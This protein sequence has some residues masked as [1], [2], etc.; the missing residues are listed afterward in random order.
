MAQSTL[1]LVALLA[2]LGTAGCGAPEATATPSPEPAREAP[3]ETVDVYALFAPIVPGQEQAWREF[4]S[5]LSGDRAEAHARSLAA[6]GVERELVWL[7]RS[8]AGSAAVVYFEGDA[9][10]QVMARRAASDESH[11]VWFEERIAELHGL[12]AEPPPPN[13]L[14]FRGEVAGVEGE[15][16]EY[17]LAAPILPGQQGAFEEL[18]RGLRER[19]DEWEESRRAKGIAREYVWEQRSPEGSYAVVCFEALDAAGVLGR[20]MAPSELDFDGWFRERI[21][22]IHGLDPEQL[23][24]PNE[25]VK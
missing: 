6:H 3:A 12:G 18:I 9:A 19:G 13:E 10:D 17:A 22:R 2:C 7:Q 21:A 25:R 20:L 4:V 24:A 1:P 16:E 14:V 23:P 15:T 8:D 5:E 11:D